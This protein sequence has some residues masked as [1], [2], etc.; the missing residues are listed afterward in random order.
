MAE[1]LKNILVR[2]LRATGQDEDITSIGDDDDT[3]FIV[4]R[5]NEA[6]D[7]LRDLGPTQINAT[8]TISIP[9]STRRISLGGINPYEI[10]EHTFRLS[11][12]EGDTPIQ[13]VSY[14]YIIQVFPKFETDT[15]EYPRYVYF[16]SNQLAVYPLVKVGSGAKLIQFKYPLLNLKVSGLNDTFDFPDRWLRYVEYYARGEYELYKGLG[17]PDYHLGKAEDLYAR[18]K[19]KVMATNRQGFK[20][21]RRMA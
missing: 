12:S 20:G 10:I 7:K 13:R 9:E 15:A 1:S 21:Y 16:D 4:D 18:I 14:E 17:Q 5:M 3:Q 2:V 8:G 6:I 11:T 19:A